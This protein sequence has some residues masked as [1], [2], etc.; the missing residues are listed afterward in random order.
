M[1]KEL[2]SDD[3]RQVI[4][5]LRD[6]GSTW[7]ETASEASKK[8]GRDITAESAR[9]QY[10]K[11]TAGTTAGTSAPRSRPSKLTTSAPRT[12]NGSKKKGHS[13]DEFRS[14]FDVTKKI[15]DKVA[16]L[17]DGDSEEYWTD[18]EFR[19]LCGVSVQNWRRH[20]ELDRY[21]KYQFKKPNFHAWATPKVVQYMR[22]ITGH[23]GN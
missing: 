9:F 19:Q 23:A 10:R 2:F 15:D 12:A 4:K 6:A 1:G 8:L 3:D 17:L 14:Q 13:L 18:D 11:T 16:E 22:E 20:A 21:R 5:G 7:E